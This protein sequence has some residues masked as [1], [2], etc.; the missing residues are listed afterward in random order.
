M[1]LDLGARL[2]A[3]LLLL[4]ALAL[5]AQ[6]KI[7]IHEI[8]VS[9]HKANKTPWDGLGDPPDLQLSFKIGALRQGRCVTQ[10]D[11]M[12]PKAPN[13]LVH[14]PGVEGVLRLAPEAQA[15]F[16]AK[17]W[18]RDALADDL[19]GGEEGALQLG[20][21]QH[22]KLGEGQLTFSVTA[23]DDAPPP[24]SQPSPQVEA[25]G[26]A[27]LS[28][29]P[30][31]QDLLRLTF[32]SAEL[33]PARP[34][35]APWDEPHDQRAE[36]K[37]T[38]AL[39]AKAGLALYFGGPAALPLIQR[40]DHAAYEGVKAAAPDPRLRVDLG[41]LVV[42]SAMQL[43]T[44]AP[45]WDLAVV[46]D[47]KAVPDGVIK[48]EVFDGDGDARE[49]IGAE[50]LRLDALKD[51]PTLTLSFGAV[52]RLLIRIERVDEAAE[53]IRRELV[54]NPSARWAPLGWATHAGQLITVEGWGALCFKGRCF[55][56]EGDEEATLRGGAHPL[57]RGQLAVALGGRVQAIGPAHQFRA[58]TSGPLY[59][60]IVGE[61]PAS[62]GLSVRARGAYPLTTRPAEAVE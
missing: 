29:P 34:D 20:E 10:H 11:L 19:I 27:K 23:L 22:L 41:D 60:G 35:G 56:P 3:A 4:P 26:E 28:D 13:A 14:R 16:I 37:E 46:V 40:G 21:G 62:G 7:Q 53:P 33:L 31:R 54:L 1:R 8:R 58:W 52:Q 25:E 61:A 5:G 18:D 2:S 49:P 6:W 17:L 44:F 24:A 30:P 38:L 15:C 39:L 42:E 43:N 45:T 47:P 36:D 50:L 55:G 9:P 32:T 57:R 48:L 59:V 12:T 51:Q